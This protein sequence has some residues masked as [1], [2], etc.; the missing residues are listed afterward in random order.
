[1]RKKVYKSLDKSASL[2][3]IKGSYITWAL[4]AV[5][6]SVGVGM[7]IGTIT[8]SLVGFLTGLVL[9][10]IAYLFV[11][12]FQSRFSERERNK[13]MASRELPDVIIMKAIPIKNLSRHKLVF[14]K[15]E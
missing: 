6:A 5:G 14:K 13:W 11:I 10:V 12:S 3:G 1:M 7:I 8:N 9:S 4:A 2:F 15:A